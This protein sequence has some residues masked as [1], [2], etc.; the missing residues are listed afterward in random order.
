MKSSA[1]RGFSLVEIMVVVAIMAIILS[2]A[3]PS[4]AKYLNGLSVRSAA[5]SVLNGLQVARGEAIRSN[6]TVILQIV[7]SLE[8]SCAET[9]QGK[10]W[11]VSHCPAAGACGGAIDKQA[12]PPVNCNDSDPVILAKGSF[13]AGD[14]VEVDLGG[15][16][17]LCYSALGRVSANASN[18][19]AGTIDP[20]GSGG[21]SFAINVRHTDEA[22]MADGGS[23][24][25]LRIA[26]GTA[27]QAKLCDPSITS[28]D[29]PRGC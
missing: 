25:C 5:E 14:R 16:A 27:G 26:V 2:V 18:C 8:N 22:C 9:A 11:V 28:S 4:L 10:H 6:N 24:R 21:G 12:V 20:S 13:E 17:A 15:S 1:Q 3:A 19:P 7:D 29:D 23:V